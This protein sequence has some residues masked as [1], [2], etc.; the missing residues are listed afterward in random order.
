M[1]SEKIANIG[2]AEVPY[3]VEDDEL[4]IGVFMVVQTVR[5]DDPGVTRTEVTV[6]DEQDYMKTLGLARYGMLRIEKQSVDDEEE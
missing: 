6:P 1:S 4:V 3:I 2:T 5:L